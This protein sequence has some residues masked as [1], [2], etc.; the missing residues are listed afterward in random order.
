[1]PFIKTPTNKIKRA[2]YIPNYGKAR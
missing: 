2:E 1:M